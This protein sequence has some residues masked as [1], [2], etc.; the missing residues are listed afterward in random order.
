MFCPHCAKEIPDDAV[1]CVGCG[2]AVQP[3]Q[4]PA[5]QTVLQTGWSD[6]LITF[7][8]FGSALLPIIGIV[9]GIIGLFKSETRKQGVSILVFGIAVTGAAITMTPIG[10]VIFGLVFATIGLLTGRAKSTG[11]YARAGAP[12]NPQT[13]V[14]PANAKTCPKCAE[15]IPL[16]A[17]VCRFCG[18]QFSEEEVAAARQVAQEKASQALKVAQEKGRQNRKTLFVIA[19]GA[20]ALIGGLLTLVMI[21]YAFSSDAAEAAKTG[22]VITY[23]A[24]FICTVP[25]LA[26]GIGFLYLGLRHKSVP[27]VQAQV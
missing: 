15:T 5:A 14:Q 10:G 20:L 16:E 18:N 21:F 6:N 2:R 7:L 27:P 11:V 19:G 3:L 4:P 23:F 17:L 25:I 9:A 24:P 12:G 22:G 8:L 26:L 13:G 1:V